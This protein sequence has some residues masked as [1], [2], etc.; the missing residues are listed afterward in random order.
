MKRILTF[1]MISAIWC[2]SCE[3]EPP[4]C[5]QMAFNGSYADIDGIFYCPSDI[6]ARFLI[7]QANGYTQ[8][9]ISYWMTTETENSCMENVCTEFSLTVRTPWP[10]VNDLSLPESYAGTVAD[11]T[12][13]GFVVQLSQKR[14]DRAPEIVLMDANKYASKLSIEFNGV[15]AQGRA[16]NGRL[17][18]DVGLVGFE[19]K[20][21]IDSYLTPGF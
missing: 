5:D 10:N 18:G 2:L 17:K 1:L 20:M 6:K 3:E 8:E 21:N 13:Q 14:F 12:A 7:R 11:L 4:S 15:K 9:E 19:D 16:F